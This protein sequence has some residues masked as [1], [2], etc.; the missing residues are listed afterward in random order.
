M[1]L[2]NKAVKTQPATGLFDRYNKD[3]P[4]KDYTV[5]HIGYCSGDAHAGH[6]DRDWADENGY[7]IRQRG[8]ENA[9]TAVDWAKRNVG[10]KKLDHLVLTGCSAGSLG[11]QVWSRKLLQEFQYERAGVIADS[12]AAIFP[13][14]SQPHF[15]KDLGIC[16][17]GVLQGDMQKKCDK[18]KIS[19]QNFYDNTMKTF[20]EVAF[21][22]L[23]SKY[24]KVQIAFYQAI[25]VSWNGVPDVLTANFYYQRL[26]EIVGPYSKNPNYVSYLV[27]SNQHCYTPFDLLYHYDAAG[28]TNLPANRRSR[29]P[30]TEPVVDWLSRFPVDP[31]A[32][33]QVSSQCSGAPTSA[34]YFTGLSTSG[35]PPQATSTK[36]FGRV[37]TAEKSK[38][39]WFR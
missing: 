3:N 20:P 31:E 19:V 35:C 30:R 1:N 18:G 6:A 22:N 2:C 9:I 26:S 5:V 17:T 23:D 10:N 14:G 36:T 16:S 29:A 34:S 8:Y 12:Y 33:S 15:I 4:F 38:K 11:T 39:R 21:A 24:D 13:T 7:P 27:T 25:H 32:D 28:P 37:Y